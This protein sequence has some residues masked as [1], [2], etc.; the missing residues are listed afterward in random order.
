ME[1]REENK[2]I[3][4]SHK[5]HFYLYLNLTG[6]PGWKVTVG[7]AS[8]PF[9]PRKRRFLNGVGELLQGCASR[10]RHHPRGAAP[11]EAAG[12]HLAA[13]QSPP[14]PTPAALCFPAGCAASKTQSYPCIRLC[15][16]IFNPKMHIVNQKTLI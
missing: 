8:T 10:L 1:K 14:A 3:L 11:P 16:C 6:K 7:Q 15:V 4:F 12:K 13:S 5:D 2:V 9:D